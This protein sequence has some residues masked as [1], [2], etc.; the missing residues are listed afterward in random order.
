MSVVTSTTSSPK[1]SAILRAT[2]LM[3]LTTVGFGACTVGKG[4]GAASGAIFEYGC[5]KNGDYAVAGVAGTVN[6]PV[7]YDLQ[8]TFFAGEPVDDLREYDPGSE[9]MSNRLIIRLQRSGKQIEQNDVL[10]FD[11]VNSYE[12]ARCV[13]GR[14]DPAT[15]K[16]DWDTTLCFRASDNGPGRLRVQYDSVVYGD[17]ALKATCSANLDASAISG[18]IPS[19][20]ST[21]PPPVVLDGSWSSWVEFQDFGSAAET[22]KTPQARDPV[23]PKFHVDFGERIYATSFSLVLTDSNIVNAFVNDLPQPAPQIGG[24]LGGDATTGR[25][26][27]D[28]ERGQGAQFFP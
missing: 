19:E 2:S 25:F 21:T 4:V 27:F 15:G 24:T 22:N 12:V 8:P 11:V 20:F 16:G 5:S 9:I 17:L 18:P 28:L 3:A 6:N 7:P 10:T 14:V 23:S 26:D 13:R 1:A